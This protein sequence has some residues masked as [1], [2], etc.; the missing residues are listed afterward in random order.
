MVNCK[1]WIIG[2]NGRDTFDGK[3]GVDLTAI[4]SNRST[5]GELNGRASFLYP[6]N[7]CTD[8]AIADC[9]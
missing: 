8:D 7:S 9:G 4:I 5:R 2:L 3:L 6:A 1:T